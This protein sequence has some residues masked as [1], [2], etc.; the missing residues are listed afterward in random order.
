[1]LNSRQAPTRLHPSILVDLFL[2]HAMMLAALVL[3][4]KVKN[5]RYIRSSM[6][7]E[8]YTYDKVASLTEQ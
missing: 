7:F 3:N 8:I 4:S 5:I 1:M 6:G 2:K